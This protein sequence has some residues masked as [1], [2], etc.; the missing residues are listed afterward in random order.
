[1][2]I[3]VIKRDGTKEDFQIEKIHNV[4]NWAIEG[5]SDVNLSDIEINVKL[6]VMDGITTSDIHSSIINAAAELITEETPNYQY[7]AGRLLNFQI[8][9]LVWGGTTPPSLFDLIKKNID[10]GYYTPK[11]LEWYSAEEIQKIDSFINH[12]EDLS[13]A[14]CST[15]Q[16]C[17]KY[18]VKNQHTKQLFETPQFRYILVAMTAFA[19]YKENRLEYVKKAYKYF[20][21]LKINLPTPQLSALGTNNNSYASCCLIELMDTKESINATNH[22]IANA[23]SAGY[24]IG[25]NYSRMRAINTPV[26]NG[27]IL[28]P[29]CIP[30]LKITEANVKAWQKNGIRGGSATINFPLWTYEIEDILQL[31]DIISGSPESRVPNLDYAIGISG[32]FYKRFLKNENITLFCPHEAEGLIDAFGLPEFD[33]LYEKY[34]KDDKLKTKKTIKA[35]ELFSLLAKQR[36]ESG[37]IYIFNIDNS[38]T[39][40]SWLGKVGMSNLC[41]SGDTQILTKDGYIRIDSLDGHE[42]PVWNG[43]QWSDARIQKTGTKQKIFK[44]YTNFGLYLNC[45]AYHKW[46]IQENGCQVVRETKDLKQGDVIVEFKMPQ[47]GRFVPLSFDEDIWYPIRKGVKQDNTFKIQSI[48]DYGKYEDTYCCHEPLENKAIFNGIL[49]GNCM[50]ITQNIEPL[51]DINDPDS[52]IGICVLSAVNWLNVKSDA[53]FESICDVIVRMLDEIIDFQDYF[54]FAAKNFCQ[55]K[56]SLGVGIIN[57]AAWLAKNKFKYTNEALPLV[58]EWMEKQQYFLI[59]A[60]IQLAKEKGKCSKFDTCKYSKGWL[61][62]D[63]VYKE[64]LVER[65][66]SMDWDSL[67]I[68]L[69]KYGTRH[70][71]FTC[72]PPTESTAV[73][74]NATNGVEPPRSFLAYKGSK[75]S[76]VPFIVPNSKKYHEYYQ[77][78]FDM[79]DNIGYLNIC[80]VIQKWM[81]MAMSCNQYFDPKHYED[82]KIPYSQLIKEM[83]HFYKGGGKSLYYS[84]TNDENKQFEKEDNSGCSSGA[85]SL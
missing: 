40:G 59:K 43:I 78:A 84:V 69:K 56:R 18:L 67:R 57:F 53:E 3:R 65:N 52:E 77:L 5:I 44:V 48:I 28:H 20:S 25:A 58:D 55:G 68:D 10:L 17:D 26:K 29:G 27:T 19:A 70:T 62:I 11:L 42:V 21:E 45:T 64:K 2:S 54:D 35:R 81:D 12:D 32:I 16:L 39:G 4:I 63:K 14:Y 38:M 24:G 83:I 37:R 9:K 82:R 13:Y 36:L 7:V 15:K 50:E 74:Q 33:E 76:S 49:T 1:M 8:R 85:C 31:K 6:S 41:V 75:K 73:A 71:T 72:Q 30:F 34:E 60:S 61:P 66:Y 23:T 80:N 22:A 79:P 47:E 46:H 51:K